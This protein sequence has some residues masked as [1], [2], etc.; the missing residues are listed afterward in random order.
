MSKTRF[1]TAVTA[2]LLACTMFT[3][4][5]TARSIREDSVKENLPDIDPGAGIQRDVSTSLYYR[6]S[7]EPYLVPVYS[8][9][10]V[11]INEIPEEAIV[12]ALLNMNLIEKG[13]NLTIAFR[14]DTDLVEVTKDNN[15]L[16]VTL[17]E[18]Y[19]NSDVLSAAE[20]ETKVLLSQNLISQA[21]YDLRMKEA[22]SEMLTE[23]RMGLYSIVNSVTA[24]DPN[25]R[26]LLSVE[27]KENDSERIHYDELGIENENELSS[28]LLE[29]L[30]F[31]ES[32]IATPESTLECVLRHLACGETEKAYLWF[33]EREGGNRLTFEIFEQMVQGM[34]RIT[35]YEMSGYSF[36]SNVNYA[37]AE[38]DVTVVRTSDGKEITRHKRI[39]MQKEGE[40]YRVDYT[41][42]AA[43]M[44]GKV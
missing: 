19:L 9:V 21:E 10:A 36:G 1:F 44:G 39:R 25:L 33:S 43:A 26:V 32:V 31:E 5:T 42:F 38:A 13:T 35:G 30:S 28:S 37:Y 11:H 34:E 27:R 40:I 14:E 20:Q 22:K 15:I 16:Y 23:R 7:G 3:G 2:L 12:R 6:L 18:D 8:E 4:C 41:S 29:P 24:Y 17:S